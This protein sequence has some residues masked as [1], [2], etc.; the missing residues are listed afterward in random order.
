M[1]RFPLC[2]TTDEKYLIFLHPIVECVGLFLEPCFVVQ[3]VTTV[4]T[5]GRMSDE[6]EQE[7]LILIYEVFESGNIETRTID[8]DS[9]TFLG[10]PFG[11]SEPTPPSS[12]SP[13]TSRPVLPPSTSPPVQTPAPVAPTTISPT[14]APTVA[15]SAR[16]EFPDER[17]EVDDDKPLILRF[18]IWGWVL[19]L[20][21]LI[22]L[23]CLKIFVDRLLDSD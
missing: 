17:I 19:I 4:F 18:P 9:V 21:G 10:D 7:M 2:S 20:V 12:P 16:T 3:G 22:V 14:A 13:T 15:P 23:W 5:M 1:H 11:D 6:I 8:V